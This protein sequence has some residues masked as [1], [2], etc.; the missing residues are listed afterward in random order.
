MADEWVGDAGTAFDSYMFQW[1]MGIGGVGDVAKEAAGIYK[2][3]YGVVIGLV[4]A[5]LAKI[6][7]LMADELKHL[8]K[9][10]APGG[11]V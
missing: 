9:E 7:K 11:M 6:D 1:T 4:Y 5:A 10:D 3:G 2:A 8:E